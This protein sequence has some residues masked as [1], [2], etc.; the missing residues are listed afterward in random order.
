MTDDF[1]RSIMEFS[2]AGF[3]EP[4]HVSFS[5]RSQF[6]L[7]AGLPSRRLRGVDRRVGSGRLA[8]FVPRRMA[9]AVEDRIGEL[10]VAGARMG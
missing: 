6:A 1:V 7:F 5:I 4:A 3:A 10:Q 9:R 8:R 2:P